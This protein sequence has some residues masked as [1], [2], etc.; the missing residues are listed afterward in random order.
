ME[1]GAISKS[2]MRRIL[3]T[4]PESTGKSE[5]SGALAEKYGG[6]SIPEFARGY[7]ENIGRPY[8]YC[9]VVHIAEIQYKEYE[10]TG[11]EHAWIFF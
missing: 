4:G 3:I 2:P 5:L 11:K 9:D 6:V 1:E 10:T 7:I 8:L